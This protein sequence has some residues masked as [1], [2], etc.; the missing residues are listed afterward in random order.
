[1]LQYQDLLKDI[2]AGGGGKAD[3]ASKTDHP[4]VG[5][6]S[7]FG[8]QL[9]YPLDNGFPL[10]TTKRLFWRGIVEELLWFIRGETN[11]RTLLSAGV[12]I[13]S[14]WPHAR[15]E[16]E[17]GE[18]MD[19]RQFEQ[20]ILA[21]A[22]FAERWGSI[23][24]GYG[25][26]WRHWRTPEGGEIDQLATVVRQLRTTPESRRILLTAWNPA[27]LK[28]MLLPPCHALAQFYVQDGRL[29]C[30]LYQRSGDTFLGVPFNIASYS[31]L[32]CLLAH[33]CDLQPGE[34]IHTLGDAH[35][36]RNHL[37]QVQEQLGR[38]PRALPTLRLDP[39][40]RE[41]ADISAAGIQLEGYNPW[42]AISAPV[43]V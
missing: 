22:E 43:S 37:D 16:H 34:F 36:Y 8:R 24:P 21:D 31:L 13:W 3:I 12:R 30:Q 7:V 26:Q 17:S 35:I 6:L 38:T 39:G 20:R 41:L 40:M 5:T 42:P 14:E 28:D 25:A 27:D 18:T 33:I 23:G 10:L 1:M 4:G 29:S 15:F 9:R 2:M 32:T 19:I 11:I